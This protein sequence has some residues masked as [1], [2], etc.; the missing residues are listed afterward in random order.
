MLRESCH[1]NPNADHRAMGTM[2]TMP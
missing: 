2:N 1:T